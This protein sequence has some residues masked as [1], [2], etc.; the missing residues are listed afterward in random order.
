MFMNLRLAQ[1]D[2]LR[3]C[4]KSVTLFAAAEARKAATDLP[5]TATQLK[6]NVRA[7]QERRARS[8]QGG[9]KR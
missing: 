9:F 3:T 8:V 1:E 7:D 4:T 6:C 5:I 2:L